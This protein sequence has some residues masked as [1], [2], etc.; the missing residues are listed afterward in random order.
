MWNTTLIYRIELLAYN[1]VG[2]NVL[3]VS[4]SQSSLFFEDNKLPEKDYVAS[5]RAGQKLGAVKNVTK[6]LNVVE[7]VTVYKAQVYSAC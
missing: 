6:K 4:L 7:R 1:L 3:L 2:N 5:V